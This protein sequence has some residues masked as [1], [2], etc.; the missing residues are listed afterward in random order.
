MQRV[1]VPIYVIH[2]STPNRKSANIY[3]TATI[4]SWRE[5][6]LYILI[7]SPMTLHELIVFARVIITRILRCS[8]TESTAHAI[9][10]WYYASS[11][12]I[13]VARLK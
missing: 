2:I 11:L 8:E 4:N 6:K 5:E 1:H 10:F 12:Y 13:F 9:A 3:N 7:S